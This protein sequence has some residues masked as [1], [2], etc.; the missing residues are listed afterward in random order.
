[1]QAGNFTAQLFVTL[2][3]TPEAL[4]LSTMG[5]SFHLER[6]HLVGLEQTSILGIF[7]RGIC[8]RHSQPDLPST[9][10]FCPSVNR[11][12]FQEKLRSLGWS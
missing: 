3:V 7:R 6:E 10:I 11:D 4:T 2:T 8:F 1:M 12:V 9:I 5:R